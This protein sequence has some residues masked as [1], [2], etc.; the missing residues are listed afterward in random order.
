MKRSNINPMP[1][2]FN[3]YINLVPDIEILQ[4][5]NNSIDQ[6]RAIDRNL[7]TK[8]DDK[9]YAPDKWTVKDIIQHII[10]AERIFGYRALRFARNDNTPL[11][12]FDENSYALNTNANDRVI[13]TLLEELIVL[14]QSNKILFEYFDDE[15]LLRIG[16]SNR[17]QISVLAL[18]FTI[19]G[20]QLHH[21]KIIEE[22]Y[23]P[24]IR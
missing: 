11:P 7:F 16:I 4:A 8:L 10:D 5:F 13:N 12:G 24:L 3:R 21:L 20:H 17:N 6:L 23:F 15:M 1:E 19:I 18:G 22:R 2:Y 14:R 9:R